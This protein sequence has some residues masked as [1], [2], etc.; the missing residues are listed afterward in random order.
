MLGLYVHIPFCLKKCHYCD[1]VIA[2]QRAPADRARFLD[3]LKAEIDHAVEKYGRLKFNT[4]YLGGGTPSSLEPVEFEAVCR[5]LQ[6]SFD[7]GF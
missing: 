1:F 4:L 7:F 3:A 6:N 2:T 5:M